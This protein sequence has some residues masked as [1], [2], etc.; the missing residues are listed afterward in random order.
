LVQRVARA[1]VTVNG[2]T[3]VI[4]RGLLVL[5]GVGKSDDAEKAAWLAAKTANLRIFPNGEGKFDLS[6]LAVKGEALVVS[7]FTLYGDCARGC[8]PDF[9]S[10]APPEKAKPLY[11]AYVESLRSLGVQVKTG[12][13]GAH[14]DVELLNDGP[15]TVLIER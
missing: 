8:R 2:S 4:S 10:A 15:V 11:E 1:G 9:G 13:F 3:R 6:L 14:M 5:L 7:Q 12:E